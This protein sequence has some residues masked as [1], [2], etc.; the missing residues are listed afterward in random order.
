MDAPRCT[1]AINIGG[2]LHTRCLLEVDHGTVL[3]PM[4]T[5]RGLT[6]PTRI[7]WFPGDRREY[8]TDRQDEHAWEGASGQ[9]IDG[10][11]VMT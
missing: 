11:W 2:T 3:H 6:E 5:A 1:W 4:H 9:L 10:L 7:S 8:I